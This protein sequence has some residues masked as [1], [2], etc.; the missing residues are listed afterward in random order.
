MR[1]MQ[2][3]GSCTYCVAFRANEL[4]CGAGIATVA[5]TTGPNSLM[6]IVRRQTGVFGAEPGHRLDKPVSG[7]LLLGKSRRQAARLLDKIQKKDMVEKVYIARV[8]RR[9][10]PPDSQDTGATSAAAVAHDQEEFPTEEFTVAAPIGWHSADNKAIVHAEGAVSNSEGSD[11]AAL[12][13]THFKRLNGD[14]APLPDGTV[15]VACRP[16]TGQRHQIRVHLAHIGWPI[17]NDS[18]YGAVLS[19]APDEVES[20]HCCV[21]TLCLAALGSAAHSFACCLIEQAE[22]CPLKLA[23]ACLPTEMMNKAR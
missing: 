6:G 13:V 7:V 12:A 5:E 18:L 15:L 8:Q 11:A 23:R 20:H 3:L 2:D 4:R 10:Q 17:A 22:H 21:D 14:S 19:F 1:C 9:A 16:K